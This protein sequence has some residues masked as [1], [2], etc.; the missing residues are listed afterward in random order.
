MDVE[1]PTIYGMY[2]V[3]GSYTRTPHTTGPGIPH[4]IKKIHIH[5]EYKSRR[6]RIYGNLA[7]VEVSIYS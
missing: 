7:V 1:Y 5:P 2:V 4:S 6:P 3:V